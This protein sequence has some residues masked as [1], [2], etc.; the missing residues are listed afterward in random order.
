M[1]ALRREGHRGLIYIDD[2]LTA[3]KSKDKC[4]RAEARMLQ[5]FGNFG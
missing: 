5:I 3:A 2:G 4:L 1:A